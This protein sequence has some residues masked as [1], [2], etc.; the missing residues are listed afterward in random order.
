[1]ET[2]E[3]L[4]GLRVRVNAEG[5]INH[6][7]I[8]VIAGTASDEYYTVRVIGKDHLSLYTE[9]ELKVVGK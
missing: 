2:N 4:I 6:G 9:D 8:G 3:E 7:D 5:D 1:M